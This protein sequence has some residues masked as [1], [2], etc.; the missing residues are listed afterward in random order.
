MTTI[1]HC[2]LF[3]D[4]YGEGAVGG[5]IPKEL[6]EPVQVHSLLLHGQKIAKIVTSDHSYMMLTESGRV[7]VNG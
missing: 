4:S 3:L 7:L 5:I 6:P 1:N 2:S